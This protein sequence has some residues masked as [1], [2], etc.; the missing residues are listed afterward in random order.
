MHSEIKQRI[1]TKKGGE[2]RQ[3]F[4]DTKSFDSAFSS[5]QIG[6]EVESSPRES[7]KNSPRVRIFVRFYLTNGAALRKRTE[8]RSR[9]LDAMDSNIALTRRFTSIRSSNVVTRISLFPD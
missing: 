4:S 1:L 2:V 3:I 7:R 5:Q 9:I 8:R 6:N